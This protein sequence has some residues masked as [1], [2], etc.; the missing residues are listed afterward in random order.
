LVTRERRFWLLKTMDMGTQGRTAGKANSSKTMGLRTTDWK[1]TDWRTANVGSAYLFEKPRSGV[2]KIPRF[3][4]IADDNDYCDDDA[5]CDSGASY[6]DETR[7]QPNTSRK[8]RP[9]ASCAMIVK[10]H[11]GNTKP[12]R[13]QNDWT[14]IWSLGNNLAFE[15]LRT[16]LL[17]LLAIVRLGAA[18][19]K[20][21]NKWLDTEGS[22]NEGYKADS[23]DNCRPGID[24]TDRELGLSDS[25]SDDI[26]DSTDDSTDFTDPT[27]ESTDR[28]DCTKPTDI[29]KRYMSDCKDLQYTTFPQWSAL[30]ATRPTSDSQGNPLV[31]APERQEHG[32]GPPNTS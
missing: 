22:Q 7:Y 3:S 11:V 12:I 1:T 17:V 32:P 13:K 20:H 26:L 6:A 14:E 24:R 31:E 2:R 29:R 30:P 5:R 15:M 8:R 21:M 9:R 25:I 28:T 27:V 16:T 10:G 18:W 4:D 23:A 19:A